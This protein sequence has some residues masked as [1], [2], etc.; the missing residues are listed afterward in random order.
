MS[1]Q[2]LKLYH[3]ERTLTYFFHSGITQKELNGDIT[4]PRGEKS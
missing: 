4:V 1:L 3:I 2:N